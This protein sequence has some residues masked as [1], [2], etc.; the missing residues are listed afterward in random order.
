MPA[1]GRKAIAAE[2]GKLALSTLR[3]DDDGTLSEA[4][5][6]P[7]AQH[8]CAALAFIGVSVT[9]EPDADDEEMCHMLATLDSAG[10][11]TS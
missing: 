9:W 5:P 4:I 6:R 7:L 3:F 11:V 1:N 8:L 10:E 2:L